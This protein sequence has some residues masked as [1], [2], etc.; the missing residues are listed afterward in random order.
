MFQ[1]ESPM[2]AGTE[3]MP[4][5]MIV[6]GT[7]HEEIAELVQQTLAHLD[8]IEPDLMT[9]E[10]DVAATAVGSLDTML[11]TL[12]A[13]RLAAAKHSMQP[14]HELATTLHATLAEVRS[15]TLQLATPVVD[16]LI[17]GVDHL[18]VLLDTLHAP[19]RAD[20]AE[21]AAP[22]QQLLTPTTA[23]PAQATQAIETS[24]S[25]ETVRIRVDLLTSLMN[26]AGELV[27]GRNQLMRALDGEARESGL[28]VILQNISQVTTALQEGIMQT[29]MQPAETVF[30]RFPR[31]IRD[32]SRQLGKQIELEII[33]SDVELDKSLVELLIDPLTHIIRNSADHAIE[34]P[35]ERVRAG[36]PATGHITLKAY[37]QDGQVNISIEDD[38]RG[39]DAARVRQ[40]ALDRG[41]LTQA[42]AEQMT[43]RELVPLI[44]T[45]GFS[46]MDAVSELSGRGVGMDVVR[47]NTERMGGTVEI[48]TT[49]G[50]G[51]TV[52]LRLPLTLA[53]IPSM[54]VGV[55]GQRFAIPQVHVVEFVSVQARDLAE[56]IERIKDSQV[57]RLRDRLLPLVHLN[58]VLKLNN[59]AAKRDYDIVVLQIGSNQFGVV[60]DELFDIEEIVVKP[61]SSFAQSNRC[62]SGATI[63]GDG[64]VIMILD[65]SGLVALAGLQFADLKAENERR[66][67][68]ERQR[69]TITAARLLPVLLCTGAP[70]EYFA[71]PQDSVLR[72][73]IFPASAIQRIGQQEFV[74]YRGHG[75]PLIRLEKHINV[76]PL[77]EGLAEIFVI[78]PKIHVNGRPEAGQA[79]IVIS[80]I[81]DALDVDVELEHI[82]LGGPG[83]MG[84]AILNNHLTLFLQPGEILNAAGH[85]QGGAA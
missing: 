3:G 55:G 28:G 63:V 15:G 19:D 83:V 35:A 68:L 20:L 25:A 82:D 65:V 51:T 12:E 14:L 60:V 37:H 50:K 66:I 6:P 57:L 42:Q 34:M 78:I 73:E 52:L 44:F 53:I 72:L 8:A 69:A 79:G 11:T 31:I 38:G 76:R 10:R 46:T 1:R 33:G 56:R 49:L 81:L 36:K 70:D 24:A 85:T 5:T 26:L 48:D 29:R 74:N 17:T 77:A 30:H 75:L 54:I 84:S 59:A 4:S 43:D 45:P 71:I 7:Y 41:I 64:R 23:P 22:L 13:I 62:F 18:R 61:I 27:L 9:M 32:V 16:A 2:N 80:S 40:K 58:S 39:I 21:V 67:E 47:S